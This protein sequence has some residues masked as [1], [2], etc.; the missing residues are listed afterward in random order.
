MYQLD[1]V[2]E[3]SIIVCRS[4]KKQKAQTRISRISR[5]QKAFSEVL[6]ESIVIRIIKK[7]YKRRRKKSED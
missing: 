6:S 3:I 1:K 7:H 5:I 2:K 4:I